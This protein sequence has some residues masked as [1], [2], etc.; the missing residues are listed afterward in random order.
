[1]L[2]E[3]GFLG[4]EGVSGVY[5]LGSVDAYTG[6]MGLELS[7]DVDIFFKVRLTI[8]LFAGSF[9]K[10]SLLLQR[11]SWAKSNDVA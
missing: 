7:G 6:Y 9:G 10:A 1:L 4:G 11:Y 5:T 3:A 2:G 8:D